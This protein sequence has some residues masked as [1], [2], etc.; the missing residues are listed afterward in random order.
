MSSSRDY[1]RDSALRAAS[2]TSGS[3]LLGPRY[4]QMVRGTEQ[5]RYRN[6]YV[7]RNLSVTNPNP[8]YETVKIRLPMGTVLFRAVG[9]LADPNSNME[10]TNFHYFHPFAGLAVAGLSGGY[11]RFCLFALKY[12]INFFLLVEPGTQTKRWVTGRNK[13]TG[14]VPANFQAQKQAGHI[15]QDQPYLSADN[16]LSKE[17]CRAAG[18]QGWIG[19]SGEDAHK[20]RLLANQFPD[21]FNK[22]A[23][24]SNATKF[25][26]FDSHTRT[27]GFAGFPECVLWYEDLQYTPTN[28]NNK[29][30]KMVVEP[31]T[32]LHM[33]RHSSND[34]KIRYMAGFYQKVVQENLLEIKTTAQ[35]TGGGTIPFA[36]FVFP[37][38]TTRQLAKSYI[39]TSRP[40]LN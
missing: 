12:D 32:C 24:M 8:N 25:V 2:S 20:H 1:I 35:V 23:L 5:N 28:A 39:G 17:L 31:I 26:H 10:K 36:H 11:S 33:P 7:P 38:M 34:Q 29:R 18:V 4:R 22:S 27:Q 9:H 3:G 6:N 19:V 37:G 16:G 40:Y 21:L 30:K 14:L 15:P 13:T